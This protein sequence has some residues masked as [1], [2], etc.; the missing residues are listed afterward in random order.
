MPKTCVVYAKMTKADTRG[1]RSSCLHAPL[2]QPASLEEPTCLLV[3]TN[4]HPPT[5]TTH[6]YQHY[7]IQNDHVL[8][9]GGFQAA[10]AA[11]EFPPSDRCRQAFASIIIIIPT[12]CMDVSY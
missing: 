9:D 4:A 10:A 6:R 12:T 7:N 11:L 3:L 1:R 2:P 5:L 8:V